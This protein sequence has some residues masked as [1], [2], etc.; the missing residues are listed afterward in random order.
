MTATTT[1]RLSISATGLRKAYD[2]KVVLDGIDIEV[3]E[4][5]IFA[6]LCPGAEVCVAASLPRSPSHSLGC[7]WP[8]A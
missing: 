4:W 7:R 2:N 8:S 3:T 6:L 5:T 1:A